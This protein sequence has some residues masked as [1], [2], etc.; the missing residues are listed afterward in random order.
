MAAYSSLAEALQTTDPEPLLRNNTDSWCYFNYSEFCTLA[1]SMAADNPEMADKLISIGD[2]WLEFRQSHESHGE[3][4]HPSDLSLWKSVGRMKFLGYLPWA[5]ALSK[6]PKYLD[7]AIE[8]FNIFYE[9]AGDWNKRE[10]ALKR[11]LYKGPETGRLLEFLSLFYVMLEKEKADCELLEKL[12]FVILQYT[13]LLISVP[14]MELYSNVTVFNMVGSIHAI[15]AIPF[16]EK[17]QSELHRTADTF[18]NSFKLQF[19][20]DGFQVEQS[21]NYGRAVLRSAGKCFQLLKRAG[22]SVPADVYDLYKKAGL[23]LYQIQDGNGA[24]LDF[25]DAGISKK[26]PEWGAAWWNI[27]LADEDKYCL[28]DADHF[29]WCILGLSG[30][31]TNNESKNVLT[32][33]NTVLKET[34]Y[35]VMRPKD[36]TSKTVLAFDCGPHGHYH[37][38]YDLLSLILRSNG[39]AFIPDPG[40]H[41]YDHSPERMASVSAC[42]HSTMCIDLQNYRSWEDDEV[43]LGGI[44]LWKEADTCLQATAWHD[45]YAHLTGGPRLVRQIWYNLDMTWLILDRFICLKEERRN[46]Q[47]ACISVFNLPDNENYKLSSDLS[48]LQTT[49]KDSENMQISIH[50]PDLV[51]HVAL[52]PGMRNFNDKRLA[53]T[54]RLTLTTNAYSCCHMTAI[55]LF[56]NNAPEITIETNEFDPEKDVEVSLLLD[57]KECNIVFESL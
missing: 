1:D 7:F 23:A 14:R 4:Q 54:T 12:V 48:S 31:H 19:R 29:S 11:D 43:P 53:E 50:R 51:R 26:G 24:Y 44:S 22:I 17:G 20:S 33:Q 36:N 28:A 34:G 52:L 10:E 6:D 16:W 45:G 8:Q 3:T 40:C 55:S 42:F 41:K 13:D 18:F 27:G 5:S 9:E 39:K 37:G 25:G 49:F 35:A 21:T 30:R 56:K 57:G 47:F 38:H 2:A 15:S 46:R 32:L